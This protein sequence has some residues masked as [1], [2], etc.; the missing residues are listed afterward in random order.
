[1]LSSI[2]LFAT[3]ASRARTPIVVE[4]FT[5][6]GCSS[7]P[8]ADEWLTR[9][10]QA[11]PV[12]GAE[13]IVMSE[14]VDYWDHDGWKDAYSS[15]VLTA[16]QNAYVA[17]LRSEGPYTPEVILDGT[18]EVQL[19]RPEEMLAAFRTAAE[20]PPAAM[21]QIERAG[22]AEIHLRVNPKTER[23]KGDVYV[24]EAIDH[25]NTDVGAG[26]NKGRRLSDV[27]VV[28]DLMKAGTVVAGQQL[29]RM[30]TLK[31]IRGEAGSKM[32]I[33]VFVQEQHMGKIMGAAML[34]PSS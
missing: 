20:E 31:P 6:Q 33:I 30:I 34:R 16:R 12:P 29:D 5:S 4:L 15:S 11:Q 3:D 1:M 27:A 17:K 24:A 28:V 8:P 7:C 32:R 26:E 9:I 18:T 19:S 2:R 14:H 25:V 10:D 13:L 22:N 23:A 21:V